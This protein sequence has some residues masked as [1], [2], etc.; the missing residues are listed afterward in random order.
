ML[1]VNLRRDPF[2]TS[3]LGAKRTRVISTP[4]LSKPRATHT[5]RNSQSQNF[6]PC[7]NRQFLPM[8]SLASYPVS[9]E[10]VG[11]A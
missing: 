4:F 2:W 6:V 10:N 8:I 3:P 7:K 11:E 9:S 1:S 5:K